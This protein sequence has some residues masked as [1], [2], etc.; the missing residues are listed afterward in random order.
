MKIRTFALTTAA[1]L[2]VAGSAFA[3][4]GGTGTG[5]SGGSDMGGGGQ[6]GQNGPTSTM[7]TG[8]SSDIQ[9]G[10]TSGMT[11]G[12]TSNSMYKSDEEKMMYQKNAA[13]M[14]PFFMDDSMSKLKSK[15]EIKSTY[16][17]M[18]S[19]S[20]ASLKASCD[21]ANGERGSYGTTT[22]TLCTSIGMM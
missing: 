5:G 10:G 21:N 3:Q 11:T 13:M 16:E 19:E 17:G 14:R 6:S 12:S 4:S 7:G 22:H 9:G 18:D 1:A 8:A 2:F 15:S 20:Q